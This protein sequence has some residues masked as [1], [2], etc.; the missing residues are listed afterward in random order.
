MNAVGWIRRKW[1]RSSSYRSLVL[2]FLPGMPA[3]CCTRC[4][5]RG[6]LSNCLWIIKPTGTVELQNL[7]LDTML[8][9]FNCLKCEEMFSYRSLFLREQ[10]NRFKYFVRILFAQFHFLELDCMYLPIWFFKYLHICILLARNIYF[11]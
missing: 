3:F 5:L 4:F 2:H 7:N 8:Y 11:G 1:S 10:F 6:V 9:I